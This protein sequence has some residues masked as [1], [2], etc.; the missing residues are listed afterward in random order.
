MNTSTTPS[1]ASGPASAWQR[2]NPS[3]E[4]VAKHTETAV[5]EWRQ[6]TDRVM[7]V[8]RVRGFS[9]AEV[10]RRAGMKEGTFSQWYSGTYI[11]RLEPHNAQVAQ[12]LDALADADIVTATVPASPAY[13]MTKIGAQ[14][15][16]TLHWA[17]VTSDMV[18][19]TLGAG[20]GKTAACK[21]YR[22]NRPHVYHVTISP[23][24]KTVFGMLN[25]LA[26][27]LEVRELNP[28]KLTRAIGEKLTRI[29]DGT[30]LIVDEAQNLIDDAINQLRHFMD[31]Y[32]CGIA[33][34]G[35]E[36]VY[37]RFAKTAGGPSYA[38]LKRRIGK[39]LKLTKPYADDVRAYI[40]AW[41]II[42]PTCV[43]YLMGIGNKGGAIGQIEKTVKLAMMMSMGNQEE[44]KV[45]HL[46]A[47][48]ANRDVEDMQ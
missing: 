39:R 38:Q 48:W 44:L 45:K 11:G 25:E 9:K 1:P 19:I 41:G 5:E 37:S 40:A 46:Q 6:L 23:H 21:Q 31:I 34:V 4:F 36:E 17:Q 7:D 47:A 16:E 10:T 12:W 27:A 35:N 22:A 24:T 42:E 26:A 8:A 29:G 32:G 43:T 28:A 13:I 3:A 14:I 15:F 30:L 33:L 18:M 2:P 20:I